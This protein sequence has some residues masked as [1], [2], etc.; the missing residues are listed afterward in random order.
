[1]HS[2]QIRSVALDQEQ[3]T[4]TEEN[5][6]SS[7][8][9]QVDYP[10]FI[11]A[12]SPLFPTESEQAP[13][14]YEDAIL[15]SNYTQ[16]IKGARL[17]PS[18]SDLRATFD[19]PVDDI[20]PPGPAKENNLPPQSR[21]E[22]SLEESMAVQSRYAQAVPEANAPPESLQIELTLDQSEDSSEKQPIT[23]PQQTEPVSL[24]HQIEPTAPPE[25]HKTE[26]VIV[27]APPESL[28]IELTL[29]QSEDS[30]EKQPITPPQQT[31]PV[32]LQ[33]QIEPTAPPEPHKTEPV[34]VNALP[35]SLQIEL[36]LDQS[37]DSSEKQPITPPQQTEPVSLQHQIEP[38]APPEP[39]KTEPVIVNA[40]QQIEPASIQPKITST[41][42]IEQR[43]LKQEKL[44]KGTFP[45]NSSSTELQPVRR[46]PV[47]Q[48][49][50]VLTGIIGIL[51]TISSLQ[52]IELQQHPGSCMSI[53]SGFGIAFTVFCA[54]SIIT[55]IS[56][57]IADR[58]AIHS[59]KKSIDVD[60]VYL[61]SRETKSA[62]FFV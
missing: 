4:T 49:A 5:V 6:D 53:Y 33:H 17:Y 11:A 18:L 24:Q 26:P 32:S 34:I 61:V 57:A 12:A 42:H 13:P 58:I 44:T 45:E 1:M 30:S 36:T 15:A 43:S 14:S 28:Q 27:N 31:E 40:L 38:T 46:N 8:D 59:E 52:N 37:E 2:T 41:L 3:I 19:E 47:L 16:P 10:T 21:L 55:E 48:I 60:E 20:A 39:H 7:N 51:C 25:P 29:D 54:I 50:V 23:P 9:I 62:A 35:E 56:L 22:D